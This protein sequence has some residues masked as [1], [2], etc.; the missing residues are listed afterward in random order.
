MEEIE[1]PFA[2]VILSGLLSTGD[3]LLADW[4]ANRTA[5]A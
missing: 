3:R 1:A 5:L 2:L 4:I